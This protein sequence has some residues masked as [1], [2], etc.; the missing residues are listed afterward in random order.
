MTLRTTIIVFSVIFSIGI[1]AV[2]ILPF[3]LGVGPSSPRSGPSSEESA[4]GIA[5]GL[6]RSDDGGASWQA[7]SWVEGSN[8]TIAGFR[9]NQVVPDPVDPAT[10]Y[11]LTDGNGLWVSRSRGDLWALV[12]DTAGG[13][14]GTAN[15]LALAV[16]PKNRLEWYVAVF[17][18]NKGS[19]LRSADGGRSFRTIYSVPAERY[20]VFDIHFDA[21]RNIIGI[22]TGQGGFLESGDQGGTWRVVRW[23][24]D[25]LV[26]LMVSPVNPSVRLVATSRGSLFRT[27]DYGASWVDVTESYSGL[28]GAQKN[29]RWLMDK[30][31]TVYLGS[32]H[33]LLR[34]RDNGTTF[35]APP[36]IIPPDALPVL[37]VAIDP[38]NSRRI[39]V[40]AST[41]LFE[42]R[43]D[44]QHW[45]ILASPAVAAGRGHRVTALLIDAVARN[46]MYAMVQP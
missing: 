22:A 8:A 29:Q 9:V 20:G 25:G 14:D 7:K 21:A 42:S 5:E 2:V 34:S 37:A 39:L 1:F 13:L 15:V 41:Q 10:F 19:V 44:G 30:T 6:F 24:A 36:I 33:G 31:G 11:L 4:A 12:A 18:K 35:E 23:F 26:R 38:A 32:R 17:Q 40:S 45:A 43:D 16:N 46:A 3:V 27:A 28:S